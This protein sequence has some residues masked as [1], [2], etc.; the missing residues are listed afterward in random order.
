MIIMASNRLYIPLLQACCATAATSHE[1]HVDLRRQLIVANDK[2]ERRRLKK[3]KDKAARQAAS[4]DG[5]GQ[6]D[7]VDDDVVG[8]DASL[9]GG[10]LQ[11]DGAGGVHGNDESTKYQNAPRR[12]RDAAMSLGGDTSRGGKGGRGELQQWRGGLKLPWLGRLERK[13]EV[14]ADEMMQEV[15]GLDKIQPVVERKEVTVVAHSQAP[16]LA[17]PNTRNGGIL[18]FIDS[19]LAGEVVVQRV[20]APVVSLLIIPPPLFIAKGVVSSRALLSFS[21]FGSDI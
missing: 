6:D 21:E 14:S 12:R 13:K 3:L 8:A 16:L 9:A 19:C 1:I 18:D 11:G 15:L 20:P 5:G 2:E 7:G 4:P 10:A 17:P